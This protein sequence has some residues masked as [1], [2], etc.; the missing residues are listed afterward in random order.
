MQD[1]NTS[2][3]RGFNF[4][5]YSNEESVEKLLA[6]KVK[7]YYSW[8]VDWLQKS[9]TCKSFES[10]YVKAYQEVETRIDGWRS[11]FWWIEI[12]TKP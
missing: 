5:T 2:R 12:K 9:C 11:K 7:T 4:V 8:E 3:S 6:N 1:R 10:W